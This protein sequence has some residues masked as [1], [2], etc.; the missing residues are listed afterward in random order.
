M[1]AALRKVETASLRRFVESCSELLVGRVLDFGAGR[2]PYRDVVEQAGGDYLPF[3]RQRFP[4]SVAEGDI[5]HLDARTGYDA[6]LCTQVIQ[7]VPEVPPFLAGLRYLLP[8]RGTLVLT[9]PTNWPVV[10][11]QDLC[12]FTPAGIT[13]LLSAA[14][15]EVV[16]CDP[17][18]TVEA[19]GASF[20]LG[21][22]AVA[23]PRERRDQ[24]GRETS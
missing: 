3:D 20:L 15:F 13:R 18:V 21:F 23:V 17:R 22:G 2:M 1:S 24:V 4:G 8:S 19:A 7:Y 5:G 14:G 11:R 6:I 9:G 16:R 10:E 12:R